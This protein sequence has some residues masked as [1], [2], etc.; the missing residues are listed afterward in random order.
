MTAISEVL[1]INFDRHI[2]AGC[3][4][5]DRFI[6]SAMAT[7]E[8]PPKDSQLGTPAMLTDRVSSDASTMPQ[9]ETEAAPKH[10]FMTRL[11]EEINPSHSDLPVLATCFVSGICDSVAF[12][13]SSVFVS[14]QTGKSLS[15]SSPGLLASVSPT[16]LS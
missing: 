9:Q 4:L 10:D 13:A 14:M 8:Q 2:S 12:N 5:H 3:W 6:E 1:T 15:T 11:R 7:I 16:R